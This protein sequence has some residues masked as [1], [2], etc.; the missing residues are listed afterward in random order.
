MDDVRVGRALRAVRVQR[1]LRQEDV[2]TAAGVSRR[3]VSELERGHIGSQRVAEL[4]AVARALE[5]TVDVAVR[6]NGA[7]LDRLLG[8]G[9]ARLH[10]LVGGL[11]RTLPE[12]VFDAEVTF[13]IYGEHG[14]ID[15]LAWHP[16]TRSLLII[17]LKTRLGDPQALVAVTDRRVRLARRIAS[18]RGWAPTSVS[19][20][21][22]FADSATNRRHV[23]DHRAL[24]SGRFPDDGHRIR[25]WLR[26]PAGSVHALS[27]IADAP[28]VDGMPRSVTPRRVRRTRDERDRGVDVA[29]I[30]PSVRPAAPM[31]EASRHT[32]PPPRR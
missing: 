13:A 14:V 1:R 23:A 24:L 10:A 8:S 32:V 6:W 15:I 27:F 19:T 25:A 7:D 2:A 31:A 3:V 16:P 4:R 28:P 5:V 17:E 18:D 22:V 30:P 11:L 9:H 20:W 21:V 26:A 12:W 29:A